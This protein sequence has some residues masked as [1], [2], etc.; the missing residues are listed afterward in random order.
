MIHNANNKLKGVLIPKTQ[1]K[2]KDLASENKSKEK[3][4]KKR[5]VRFL[6]EKL[7]LR[8]KRRLQHP[9]G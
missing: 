3:L 6:R 9:K 5:A 4:E 7:V 8:R 1:K 2:Q